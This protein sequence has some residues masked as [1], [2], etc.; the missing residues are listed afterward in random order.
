MSAVA[1]STHLPVEP[2]QADSI[3]PM[4]LRTY[5]ASHTF[6]W[7]RELIVNSLQAGATEINF[8]TEW[9]AAHELGVHRRMVYDN[10]SGI[11][12][13]YL[14][15]FLAKFGG[16]GKSI[17]AVM[18]NYGVGFKTSCLPWNHYGLVAIT[19]HQGQEAMIWLQHTQGADDDPIGNY[20]ARMFDLTGD[21]GW[22]SV[23]PLSEMFTVAD[24]GEETNEF[25]EDG[26]D[27]TK[28]FPGTEDGLCIVML[29]G[30]PE[31]HTVLGDPNRDEHGKYSIVQYVN[32]R[33]WTLP[34]GVRINVDQYENWGD[35]STWH[36]R[37]EDR[38]QRRQP[39]G[40]KKTIEN[41]MLLASKT[42][43]VDP[44]RSGQIRVD[45]TEDRPGGTIHWWLSETSKQSRGD[46]VTLPMASLKYSSHEGIEEMYD[47]RAKGVGNYVYRLNRF[48]R[49]SSV[50][51]RLAIVVS[52]DSTSGYGVS[53]FPDQSRTSLKYETRTN[54]GQDLDWEWWVD[55]WHDNLPQVVREEIDAYYNDRASDSSG[56]RKEDY[57]RLG[58]R[59]LGALKRKVETLVP[60]RNGEHEGR[61]SSARFGSGRKPRV[62]RRKPRPEGGKG[63]QERGE[64]PIKKT[65]RNATVGLIHTVFESDPEGAWA[66]QFDLNEGRG[67]INRESA[68][69]RRA[70]QAILDSTIAKRGQITPAQ[71]KLVRGA[72]ETAMQAVVSTCLT[73]VAAE[74][75]ARPSERESLTSDAAVSTIMMGIMHLEHT[76]SG[77]IGTA[78]SPAKRTNS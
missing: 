8:T 12:P 77:Y 54:G 18:D 55:A 61:G 4:V 64:D 40:L 63:Q 37:P 70:M 25:I 15:A 38:K 2:M 78:L 29:G 34:E 11:D 1:P 17:G 53:V 71:E 31:E 52:L 7:V 56:L 28:V 74:V 20:G 47:V 62:M 16:S 22:D 59:Y 57:E 50:R 32:S 42:K 10:G 3:A 69:Y 58:Q 24:D 48:V 26:V 6:Q 41:Q 35:P 33:F 9:Q 39:V 67:V 51:D 19:R 66:V 72:I 13:R 46:I 44:N 65:R 21:G 14:K 60:G 76:A 5:K 43:T 75:A 45:G 30:S 68:S 27:W 49:V 23:V 73:E 36:T